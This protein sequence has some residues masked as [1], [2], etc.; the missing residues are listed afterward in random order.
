LINA[1]TPQQ[2]ASLPGYSYISMPISVAGIL[3]SGISYEK[4]E[5]IKKRLVRTSDVEYQDSTSGIFS[6]LAGTITVATQRNAQC[7]NRRFA[8][9]R[10]ESESQFSL[11]LPLSCVLNERKSLMWQIAS[12]VLP[13]RFLLEMKER[14]LP[15]PPDV[16]GLA[17]ELDLPDEQCTRTVTEPVNVTRV[18]TAWRRLGIGWPIG[19]KP[20]WEHLGI[21]WL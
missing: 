9:M 19:T 17:L 5:Q 14:L 16:G 12:A 2:V 15:K 21:G 7:F 3:W 11:S 18:V 6:P 1:L 10:G 13:T 20:S 4:Q 8:S